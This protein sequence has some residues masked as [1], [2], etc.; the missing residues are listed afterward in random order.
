MSAARSL[1]LLL[2][3]LNPLN[4]AVPSQSHVRTIDQHWF[5]R[6]LESR[7]ISSSVRKIRRTLKHAILRVRTRNFGKN[8]SNRQ[9]WH[10]SEMLSAGYF[11][12]FWGANNSEV[13]AASADR[14]LQELVDDAILPAINTYLGDQGAGR[15][16]QV[17]LLNLW[18]TVSNQGG[19]HIWHIHPDSV[20]SGV[21]YVDAGKSRSFPSDELGTLVLSDPRPQVSPS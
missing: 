9:S 16:F 6:F 7:A 19:N 13:T 20:I 21:F 8:K 5:T 1:V 17:T 3:A 18:A 12:R 2:L 4:E 10:S 11:R 14:A 15:P